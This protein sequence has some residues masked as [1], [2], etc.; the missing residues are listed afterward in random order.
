M[1]PFEDN[2]DEDPDFC[3]TDESCTEDE[4]DNYT[5][6]KGLAENTYH[7]NGNN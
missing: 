4:L 1:H 7:R 5:N 6:D 2:S 3:P